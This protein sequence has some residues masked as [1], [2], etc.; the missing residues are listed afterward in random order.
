MNPKK[1]SKKRVSF[2]SH[3]DVREYVPQPWIKHTSIKKRERPDCIILYSSRRKAFYSFDK[4][5]GISVW[6]K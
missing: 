4:R 3:V 2:S 6:I 1:K 5:T